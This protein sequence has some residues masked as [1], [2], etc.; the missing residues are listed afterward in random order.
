MLDDDDGEDGDDR[1]QKPRRRHGTVSRRKRDELGRQA[2]GHRGDSQGSKGKRITPGDSESRDVKCRRSSGR[3]QA[4]VGAVGRR[5]ATRRDA[6]DVTGQATDAVPCRM[7]AEFL[8]AKNQ[9]ATKSGEVDHAAFAA[10]VAGARRP[11]SASS[12]EAQRASPAEAGAS[13]QLETDSDKPRAKQVDEADPQLGGPAAMALCALWRCSGAGD[14]VGLNR[15][16][17]RI[18]VQEA[19]SSGAGCSGTSSS[20]GG[21]DRRGGGWIV[22]DIGDAEDGGATALVKAARAGSVECVLHLIKA[23]ADVESRDAAGETAMHAAASRGHV[24]IIDALAAAGGRGPAG[25]YVSPS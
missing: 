22:L 12:R 5:L 14:G 8:A 9:Q 4:S 23:R 3:Q 19:S 24:A 7:L 20:R 1:V 17:R 25:A 21:A 6:A 10:S 2:E 16:L 15:A 13:L 11:L 18:A